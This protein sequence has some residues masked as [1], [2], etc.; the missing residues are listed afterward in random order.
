MSSISRVKREMALRQATKLVE[1]AETVLPLKSALLRVPQSWR[2]A[3][4]GGRRGLAAG[5]RQALSD[6]RRGP[7]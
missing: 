6:L 1:F 4:G 2:R 7:S 3:H 5:R